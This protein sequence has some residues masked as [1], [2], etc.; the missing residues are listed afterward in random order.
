MNALPASA[1]VNVI[2]GVLT[3]GGSPLSLN[4]VFV[5][6]DPSI[7]IGSVLGFA[8]LAAVNAWFGADSTEA[9]Y[10]AIYFAGFTNCDQLPSQLYFVQ[11]NVN[12]V[13]AYLR[14]GTV[15]GVPL[16]TLQGYSGTITLEVNGETVSSANI[17]LSSATSFTNAAAL[18]T[19]GL[20]SPGSIFNGTGTVVGSSNQLQITAVAAGALHIGDTVVGTNIPAATTITA[21]GTGTGGVGTYTMSA[22]ATGSGSGET[23]HV[24][25][26]ATCTY[27][28][29][30]AAFV[31]TS[32]TTGSAST[33]AYPTDTSLSPD[34]N[35][36]QIYGAVLSQGAA[37][38]TAAGTMATVVAANQNWASFM[39]T[40]EPIL[41]LKLAFAA[42]A[43][44]QN[45]RYA[46]VCFDSDV[47][48]T[49]GSDPSCFAQQ[50]IGDNGIISV[51]NPDGTKAAFI[52]S[53]IAS[54][55]FSEINGRTTFAYRS[56]AGLVPDVTSLTVYQNLKANGYNAYCA[57]AT[58]NANF[59]FLQ[60]G[61][62]SGIWT[63]ID[64][65]ID[66]IYWNAAFQLAFLNLLT[67]IKAVP[68]TPAGYN[69]LR[70]TL[71][72]LITAMGAFGAWVSGVTLAGNQI[73][74]INQAAGLD[75]STTLSSQGWYLQILDPGATARGNRTSPDITFW[76]TDGGAIQQINMS[77]IDVE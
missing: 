63:W 14:G 37:P 68:Y 61:Q 18:I 39:T 29:Q 1:F 32:P 4:A 59:Q 19:S 22:T 33:I 2:P 8:N 17:N 66:Q 70:E 53:I 11:Y 25:S 35:L 46:Y 48:P 28:S 49:Q 31:I 67:Q 73:A 26:A 36:T 12:A 13:A 71:S 10:A 5:D 24:T 7:P 47:T 34:L 41:S 15:A 40:W 54:I 23:I 57:V 43:T 77:S 9:Q 52:C 58:A 20:Q 65:Y 60:P 64:P 21:F 51:W 16:A 6:Q 55:N 72:P 3:P 30:R 74:E 76:Y 27:D 42:W 62:I 38:A 50:V 44:T 69:L 45:Q 75:I 56:Q